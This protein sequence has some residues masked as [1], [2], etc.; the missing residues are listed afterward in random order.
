MRQRATYKAI[1][2]I[3]TIEIPVPT[4]HIIYVVFIV[5]PKSG[6]GPVAEKLNSHALLA[7]LR[8]SLVQTLEADMAS[9]VRPR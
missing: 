8:V 9:L 4:L 6:T 7:R 3:Y 2:I 5:K 1:V